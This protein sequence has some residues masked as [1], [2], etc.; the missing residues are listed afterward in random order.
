MQCLTTRKMKHL[1]LMC[2]HLRN[3]LIIFDVRQRS[4]LNIHLL[5]LSVIQVKGL[6]KMCSKMP[7]P[8]CLS[9]VLCSFYART[10]HLNFSLVFLRASRPFIAFHTIHVLNAFSAFLFYPS[11]VAPKTKDAIISVLL[12]IV[13]VTNHC[14][15]LRLFS[16]FCLSKLLPFTNQ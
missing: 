13:F 11:L 7:V 6:L 4:S 15:S 5:A 9:K 10:T 2:G 16:L 1:K 8:A 12:I 14:L 3:F